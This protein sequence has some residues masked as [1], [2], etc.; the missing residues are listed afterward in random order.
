MGHY[1][2]LEAPVFWQVLARPRTAVRDG[3]SNRA[4][5][6]YSTRGAFSYAVDLIPHIS[7]RSFSRFRHAKMEGHHRESR[8]R[9]SGNGSDFARASEEPIPSSP[10]KKLSA[11][12]RGPMTRGKPQPGPGLT[13]QASR[14][15]VPVPKRNSLAT[16]P[17]SRV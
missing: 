5:V 10:C 16:Y 2:G 7:R 15:S 13:F 14:H 8:I 11:G 3:G 6:V 4:R 9:Q 1:T 12:R 17:G